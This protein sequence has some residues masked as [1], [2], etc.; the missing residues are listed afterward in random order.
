MGT[1]HFYLEFLIAWVSVLKD[2]GYT[3]PCIFALEY[4]LVPDQIYPTQVQQVLSGYKFLLSR[5]EDASRIFLSGDSAGATLLLSLLLHNG[6]TNRW[7][8]DRPGL[9][10][11]ISPWVTIVSSR[12]RDTPSDYLNTESLHSYAR[13]F[14]GRNTSV[15][16]PLASGVSVKTPR[17]GVE[18]RH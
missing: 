5:V 14:V 12:N 13:Q 15:D 6:L 3:N 17:S 10:V 16:N 9:A 2:L 4:T 1:S 18:R 8:E 7:Q 11:L